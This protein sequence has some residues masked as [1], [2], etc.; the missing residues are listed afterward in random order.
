MVVSGWLIIVVALFAYPLSAFSVPLVRMKQAG[1]LLAPKATR[2]HRAAERK[3]LRRN[4][5]A[6]DPAEAGEEVADPSKQFDV[7]RKLSTMLIS[8]AAIVPVAG[9]A[10]LPFVVVGATRLPF[11]EVWSVVKKLLLL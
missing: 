1:L 5:I 3:L 11:K 6:E 4:V 7:T 8:R 9:V 10:L 2:F